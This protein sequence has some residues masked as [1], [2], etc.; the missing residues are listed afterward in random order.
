LIVPA[1]GPAEGAALEA[2][3]GADVAAADVAAVDGAADVAPAALDAAAGVF[4]LLEHAARSGLV[5][6]SADAPKPA[7]RRKFRR[8]M[9]A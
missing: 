3:A 9:A 7:A 5:N 6:A 2:A 8:L 4:L 1:L